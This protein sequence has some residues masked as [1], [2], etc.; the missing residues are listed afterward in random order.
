MDNIIYNYKELLINK[1]GKNHVYS[2][3]YTHKNEKDSVKG[4]YAI[5]EYEVKWMS[6]DAISSIFQEIKYEKIRSKYFDLNNEKQK[7]FYSLEIVDLMNIDI[8][9]EQLI[10]VIKSNTRQGSP[11]KFLTD[12]NGEKVNIEM[13][14]ET[15][16]NFKFE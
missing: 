12:S 8:L 1:S 15:I 7:L 14:F 16:A 4:Y 13:P 5:D 3:K 10:K 2:F 11:R 9:Y 6:V